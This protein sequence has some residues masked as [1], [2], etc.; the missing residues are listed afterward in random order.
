MSDLTKINST[1]LSRSLMSIFDNPVR[2]KFE[3]QSRIDRAPIRIG[4]QGGRARVAG[5]A[6]SGDR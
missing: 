3:P 6:G 4:H 2:H 1:H 5:A